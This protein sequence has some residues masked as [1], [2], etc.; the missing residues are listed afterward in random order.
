MWLWLKVKGA[1]RGA[2][3]SGFGGITIT[4]SVDADGQLT[5]TPHPGFPFAHRL[6]RKS[7]S[8][9]LGAHRR[10]KQSSVTNVQQQSV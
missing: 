5:T 7:L 2:T 10:T 1:A 3:L 8:E 9:L 6:K 4:Q